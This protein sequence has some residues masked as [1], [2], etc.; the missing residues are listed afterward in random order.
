MT[1]LDMLCPKFSLDLLGEFFYE[2]FEYWSDILLQRFYMFFYKWLWF[3]VVFYKWLWYNVL[4]E[5]W[6]RYK[7][8]YIQVL[9]L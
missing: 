7:L 2:N 8:S 3:N 9:D 4:R 1:E 5:K 6:P